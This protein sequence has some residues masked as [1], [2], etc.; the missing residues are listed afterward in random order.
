LNPA[1]EEAM[2]DEAT[3][4]IVEHLRAIRGDIGAVREDVR[5]L[6]G[7][8]TA[9]ETVVAALVTSN[10]MLQHSVDRLTD[11]I[12]CIERRFDLVDPSIAL[13]G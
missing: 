13:P 12:E 5:Q 7:R 6:K 3:N 4:L 9:V 1:I 2:V 11:R 8:M 10:T